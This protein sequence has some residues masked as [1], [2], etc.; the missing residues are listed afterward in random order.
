M[1]RYLIKQCQA[2]MKQI[3][4][5]IYLSAIIT[6]LIGCEKNKDNKKEFSDSITGTWEL[7]QTSGGMMPGAT[8]FAAGNGKIIKFTD[9]A[10]EMYDND[11][12]IKDGLYAIV[13]D[14][15]VEAS[16]CLVFPPGQF[17]K[18]I[19]Y[20]GNINS[21]KQFIQITGNRLSFVAGCYAFDAGHRSEY[22]KISINK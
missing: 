18:R 4:S 10:Y 1:Q 16:V 19:I 22:E 9:T 11:Q 17:T 13:T 21:E 3:I 14:T 12:L 8:N 6:F 20:D 2:C 5:I 15:T 7:R